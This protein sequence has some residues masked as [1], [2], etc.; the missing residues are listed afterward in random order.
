MKEVTIKGQ[1]RSEFGKKA[2]RQVRSEGKVPCVIY[3]GSSNIHFSTTLKELKP[4]VYSPEFKVALI[5][6]DG[7][8]TKCI[9]K[10]LQFN[11]ITDEVTHID[12]LELV[13]A[14]KLNANIPLKFIGQSK[15]VKEGGR[16]VIKMNAINVRITPEQLADAIEVDITNLEIGK[17][18]R[19]EDIKLENVEIMHNKRI[20]IAAVVTTRALKQ[21][22]AAEAKEGKK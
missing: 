14:K 21:A 11:K 16:F 3:G 18:L 10:D 1:L 5:D 13:P 6:V 8:A 19:I 12:F 22:E 7:K 9:M 20:P 17:N 4:L 2:S 15:G